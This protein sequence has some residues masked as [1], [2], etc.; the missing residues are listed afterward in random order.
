VRCKNGARHET[1]VPFR[2]GSPEDPMS[3]EQ[4]TGKFR[5]LAAR[6]GDGR[7]DEIVATVAAMERVDDLSK[8]ARLLT[9]PA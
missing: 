4:L 2:K 9:V 3:S 7:I 1:V 6:I 5:T 8:F